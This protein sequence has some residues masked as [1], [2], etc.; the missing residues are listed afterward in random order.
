MNFKISQGE[1]TENGPFGC[2]IHIL[3]SKRRYTY[4]QNMQIHHFCVYIASL[5]LL[6]LQNINIIFFEF[7]S[8]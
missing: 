7:D 2:K 8:V 5:K 4:Q 3:N 1:Y 6:M